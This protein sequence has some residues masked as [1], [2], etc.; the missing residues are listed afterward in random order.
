MLVH[1][2]VQP[3]QFWRGKDGNM[4]IID[5]NRAE[6]MLYDEAEGKYCKVRYGSWPQTIYFGHK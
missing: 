1:D 3:S 2:D 4:K 5:F 6:A